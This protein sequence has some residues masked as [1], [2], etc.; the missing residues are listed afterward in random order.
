MLQILIAQK[1]TSVEVHN[2]ILKC[3]D[4]VITLTLIIK[5][6]VRGRFFTRSSWSA[7]DNQSSHNDGNPSKTYPENRKE[8]RKSSLTFDQ[9]Y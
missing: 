3:I 7:M 9:Y 4:F 5:S 2:V 8:N 6:G 1:D